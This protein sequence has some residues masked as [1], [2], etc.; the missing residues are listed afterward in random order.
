V[1]VVHLRKHGGEEE[2]KQEE[3]EEEEEETEEKEEQIKSNFH[4]NASLLIKW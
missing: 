2:E 3:E 1:P 4:I